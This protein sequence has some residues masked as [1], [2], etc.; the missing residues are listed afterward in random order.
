[1]GARASGW[2]HVRVAA[3]QV[4]MANGGTPQPPLMPLQGQVDMETGTQGARV[5]QVS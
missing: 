4:V 5:A 2:R 3:L 1:M